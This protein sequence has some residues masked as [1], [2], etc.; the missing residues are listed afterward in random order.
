MIDDAAMK[1]S[2]SVGRLGSVLLLAALWAALLPLA[3]A[4]APSLS[5]LL[6]AHSH[7]TLRGFVP[8]HDHSEAGH[9][10]R[11]GCVAR[12]AD[13]D[14]PVVVCGAEEIAS[15]AA[16]LPTLIPGAVVPVAATLGSRLA[17]PLAPPALTLEVTTPPPRA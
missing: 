1:R 7:A 11:A 9:E 8:P 6:P 10:L 2:A 13:G 4:A 12:G 15:F 16:A 3:V 5:A 14:A 17:E